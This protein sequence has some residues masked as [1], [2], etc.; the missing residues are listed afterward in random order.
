[1]AANSRCHSAG[2]GGAKSVDRKDK[3]RVKNEKLNEQRRRRAEEEEKQKKRKELKEA[4][5]H[6]GEKGQAEAKPEEVAASEP[7]D[8]IHP[9]RR[10]RI[11]GA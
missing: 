8:G 3:L 1:M 10:A 7:D 5:K 9:S 4:K 2:G 11:E 6:G